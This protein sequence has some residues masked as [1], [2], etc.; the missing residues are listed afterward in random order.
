MAITELEYV[1]KVMDNA[2][3]HKF[4]LSDAMMPKNVR[5]VFLR[6]NCTGIIQVF[7]M[8]ESLHVKLIQMK[9]QASGFEA[10]CR[11][12]NDLSKNVSGSYFGPT[13][14]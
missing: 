8:I 13:M 7:I 2:A 10:K 4:L 12:Q 11:D 14:E 9:I 6:P 5:I 3:C 1:L